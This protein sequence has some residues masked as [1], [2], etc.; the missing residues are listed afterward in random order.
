MK[1]SEA[2]KVLSE[3]YKPDDELGR[4]CWGWGSNWKACGYAKRRSTW[5]LAR[6]DEL[7]VAR[8]RWPNS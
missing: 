7:P 4:S 1:V 6:C 5:R 2:I 8:R 3:F